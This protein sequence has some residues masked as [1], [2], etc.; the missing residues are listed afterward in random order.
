MKT[1][2]FSLLSLVLIQATP[3]TAFA[4]DLP[5]ATHTAKI[6]VELK[7]RDSKGKNDKIQADK[8]LMSLNWKTKACQL[9][10]GNGVFRACTFDHSKDLLNTDGSLLV[11]DVPGIRMTGESIDKLI[12]QYALADKKI[13]STIIAVVDGTRAERQTGLELPFYE[14]ST[15]TKTPTL[16][17]A[18]DKGAAIVREVVIYHPRFNG[19]ALVL[20]FKI[21]EI[22]AH[23]GSLHVIGDNA[24]GNFGA[25]Q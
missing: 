4:D 17:N 2:F 22:K 20:S 11:K 7:W 5:P 18:F 6:E 9:D 14:L 16:Y 10:L 19:K 1:A 23:K 24:D 15:N 8:V 13:S 3:L 25:Q 12:N 21:K